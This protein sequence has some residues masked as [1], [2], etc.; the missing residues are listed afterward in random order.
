M[1]GFAAKAG[2]LSPQAMK[3]MRVMESA[4]LDNIWAVPAVIGATLTSRHVRRSSHHEE[5]AEGIEVA[6][7][8]PLDGSAM[9]EDDFVIVRMIRRQPIM[10]WLR[11]RSRR[12]GHTED[13][14]GGTRADD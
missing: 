3:P 6:G 10:M 7:I 13:Y 8:P 1:A 4:R 5:P 2:E 12:S 9:A 14:A 11:Q